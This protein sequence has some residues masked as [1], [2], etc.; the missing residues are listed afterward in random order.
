MCQLRKYRAQS[1]SGWSTPNPAEN[2]EKWYTMDSQYGV[3]DM[4]ILMNAGKQET[5]VD[6]EYMLYTTS[7]VASPTNDLVSFWGVRIYTFSKNFA[8]LMATQMARSQYPTFFQMAMD[9]L[10]IQASAV[11]CERAFSSGAETLTA[12]RNRIKPPIMEA[13]QMLKF[14]L[15][16]SRL[17]FTSDWLTTEAAMNDDD[18][19]SDP[20]LWLSE[21]GGIDKVAKML[22]DEDE[23]MQMSK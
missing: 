22:L 15:R 20:L 10:P 17:S 13:L 14:A 6:Q 21:E 2:T 11:P 18:I 1:Q 8:L 12:R 3:S 4:E 19:C 23:I 9:Y 5:S 7:P 16:K